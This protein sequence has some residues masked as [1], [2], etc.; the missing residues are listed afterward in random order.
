MSTPAHALDSYRAAFEQR[1][2]QT[3]ESAA[4]AQQRQQAWAAFAA[5][6]F[7]NTR[8][9]DWKYT[10][11]RRLLRRKF[12]APADNPDE[13]EADA[14]AGQIVEMPHASRLVFVDGVFSPHLSSTPSDH[15]V[16]LATTLR[17]EEQ[18]EKTLFDNVIDI[19]Q[20]RFAALN[21]ALFTDGAV[22]NV[23][24]NQ[25]QPT[26]VYLVFVSRENG[27]GVAVHPRV[28]V[29]VGNASALQLVEHHI[30]LDAADNF[31]NSICEID[32]G[33]G[34]RVEHIRLQDEA[35]TGFSIAGL[36][37]R[38]A[39]DSE[40]VSH[41]YCLGGAL[42][43]NDVVVLLE[44]PGARC[45]LNGLFMVRGS[46]HVD[47]HVRIDHL[48][49]HTQ[50]EQNYRGVADGRA[51]GVYNGKVVVH[52]GADKTDAIQSSKNL[53]LSDQAEIDTKPELEIYADDVKCRHG[54]TV[55]QL[56]ADALFY[57]RSRGIDL[58]TARAL[59]TYA[60]AEDV[61]VKAGVDAVRDLLDTRI[62]G[63]L[64]AQDI[65][66]EFV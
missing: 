30:S 1:V 65:I 48:A 51:R 23:A 42:A 40:F 28:Q 19:G 56:D 66:R 18:P 8:D 60:F 62:L 36:H 25:K 9:E 27:H 15:A 4:L 59:L 45:T 22:V 49:M 2:Q 37:V 39:R 20:H 32:L 50:S 61:V 63:L 3:R 35:D 13:I 64:P 16:S 24:P 46:Q 21:T 47:N 34:A 31:V 57:L 6:G 7:P 55:G 43:R 26:V 54:A 14:L 53:L 38:Q 12:S 33:D 52:V 41:N 11:L 44:E 17:N 5:T 10:N 58:E 29:N